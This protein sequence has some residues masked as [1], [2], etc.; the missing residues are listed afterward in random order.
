MRGG[1]NTR[2]K[3]VRSEHP[4][5]L[6]SPSDDVTV[7]GGLASVKAWLGSDEFFIHYEGGIQ[8]YLGE[9]L[10]GN[11]LLKLVEVAGMYML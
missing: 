10:H 1:H 4:K 8:N 3:T 2:S 11:F 7:A 6:L 9:D 5:P